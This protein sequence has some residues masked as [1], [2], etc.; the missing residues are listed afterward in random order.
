MGPFALG[1]YMNTIK[2]TTPTY[3]FETTAAI[4]LTDATGVWVTFADQSEQEIFTKTGADL[5]ISAQSVA[6]F[7]TQTET[8]NLPAN[9]KVQINW[10]F[11]DNGTEKR[12]ASNKMVMGATSNLI[13][14]VL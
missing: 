13:N 4:N 6:V 11:D 3:I 1:E 5:D 2:G 7:L 8:L 9:F 12:A 10:T 14:E